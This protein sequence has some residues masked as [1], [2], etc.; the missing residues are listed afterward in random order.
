MD[1]IAIEFVRQKMAGRPHG[2]YPRLLFLAPGEEISLDVGEGGVFFI[3]PG[4]PARVTGAQGVYD[5][6]SSNECQLWHDG[7]VKLKNDGPARC[8]VKALQAVP[9]TNLK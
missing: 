3:L 4:T 8:S 2:L 1:A 7:L 5:E 6:A 9:I